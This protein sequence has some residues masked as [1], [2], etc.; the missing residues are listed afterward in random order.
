MNKSLDKKMLEQTQERQKKIIQR[1]HKLIKE[2][3][4]RVTQIGIAITLKT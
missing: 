1:A 3:E 4:A 2:H